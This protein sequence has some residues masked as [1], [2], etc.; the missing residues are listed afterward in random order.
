MRLRVI[1]N[2]VFELPTAESHNHCKEQPV[3]KVEI[4]VVASIVLSVLWVVEEGV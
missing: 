2:S 4:A 1:R 3:R